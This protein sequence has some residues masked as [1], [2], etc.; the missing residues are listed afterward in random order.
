M[1][2]LL[3]FKNF[4]FYREKPVE[5]LLNIGTLEDMCESLGIGFQEL[6][7]YI[8]KSN[9]D[10]TFHLLYYGY[11]TACQKNYKKPKYTK[12]EAQYW[13][14]HLSITSRKSLTELLVQLFGKLQKLA[15]G[16]VKKKVK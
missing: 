15:K 8:N 3:P 2:L 11:L 9:E 6:E 5:I 14:S 16:E 1:I 7:G 12:L 10:F 4:G 13:V